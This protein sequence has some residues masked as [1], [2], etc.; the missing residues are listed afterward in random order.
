MDYIKEK[1]LKLAEKVA[2]AQG[3]EVFDTEILGKGRLLV[4]VTI[5]KEGGITLDD[6]EKFSRALE[7]LLDVENPI[8]GPYNLEVSSPGLDR[9]LRGIKD[10]EK[11]KGKLTRIVTKEEIEGRNL[12]V[13]RIVKVH[14]N[15]IRLLVNNHEL[16]IPLEKISK[17]RLE[18]EFSWQK[19]SAM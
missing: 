7:A 14:G 5:D 6:C 9:P 4:R 1:V 11:N 19:N 17:A 18:V 10:F 16:D 15:F 2:E 3:A 12:F 13:G 8:P